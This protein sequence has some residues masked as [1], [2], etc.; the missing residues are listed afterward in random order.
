MHAEVHSGR[1]NLT[2]AF[3]YDLRVHF[4]GLA[5]HSHEFSP[6]TS[7]LTRYSD[8]FERLVVVGRGYEKLPFI[9]TP[10]TVC[11]SD[12]VTFEVVPDLA[13]GLNTFTKAGEVRAALERILPQVDVVIVRLPGMIGDYAIDIARELGKPTIVEVVGCP[14]DSMWN[15]GSLRGKVWAPVAWA[16]L[17]RAVAS[18]TDVLYVTSEFLQRRYPTKGRSLACSDVVIHRTVGSLDGRMAR[19][20]SKRT[21]RIGTIGSLDVL[22]KGLD[23]LLRASAILREKHLDFRVSAVGGGDQRRW[24]A[25]AERLG[26]ADL[27]RFEGYMPHEKVSRWLEE[28]DLYV[29]PSRQEGLPRSVI[30]AMSM[31]CPV[32]GSSAGGLPELLQRDCIHRPGDHRRLAKIVARI[33]SHPSEQKRLAARS[34]GIAKE[35]LAEKLQPRRE[36]FYREVASRALAR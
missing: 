13:R 15:H 20:D 32:A 33:H 16:S 27:V 4:D 19:I 17:R 10:D 7:I 2:A 1:M 23:T 22:F 11:S 24:L 9:P 12:R 5:W 29:Q 35:F 30:E 26:V 25:M 3:V 6:S 34:L 28:I 18:A 14:W 31:G 21:F 36:A 8:M